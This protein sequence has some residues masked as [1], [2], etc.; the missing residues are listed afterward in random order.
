MFKVG[1][2]KDHPP[3]PEEMSESTKLLQKRCFVTE[4]DKSTRAEKEMN[5]KLKLK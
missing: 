3:I 2:Y 1:F 5:M 4:P